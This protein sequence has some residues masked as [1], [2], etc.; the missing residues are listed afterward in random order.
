MVLTAYT[1]YYYVHRDKSRLKQ[2]VGIGFITSAILVTTVS[3]LM[4]FL[5]AERVITNIDEVKASIQQEYG[6]ELTDES[7][8]NLYDTR[9]NRYKDHLYVVDVDGQLHPYVIVGH[10][11]HFVDTSPITK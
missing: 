4:Y 1:E 2:N 7:I 5:S 6:F 3:G 10:E 8:E 9:G 11:F